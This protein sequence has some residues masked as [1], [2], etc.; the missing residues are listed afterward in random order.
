[1]VYITVCQHVF[2][3]VV[4][5]YSKVAI[6]RCYFSGFYIKPSRHTS[7]E[8][9]YSLAKEHCRD[10]KRNEYMLCL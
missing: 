1:M 10:V 5:F 3:G 9:M 2:P 8:K 4:T 6:K 7:S